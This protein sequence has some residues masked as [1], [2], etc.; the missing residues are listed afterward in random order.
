MR[1]LS[2]SDLVKELDGVVVREGSLSV[3][4]SVVTR[5][6]KVKPGCLY[7]CL[8]SKAPAVQETEQ[9][10]ACV[11]ITSRPKRLPSLRGDITVIQVK[12]TR[13]AYHH[14]LAWYRRLLSTPHLAI[15]GSYGKTTTKEMVKYLLTENHHVK[16][17]K[18]NYNLFRSNAGVLTRMNENTDFGIF[19][20]GVGKKGHLEKCVRCFS[21]FSVLITGIGTDHIERYGSQHL[22]AEEKAKLLKG[23]G[24]DQPIFLNSECDHSKRF[25]RSLPPGQIIWFGTGEQAD[26]RGSHIKYTDE[27]MTFTLTHAEKKYEAF[28]PAFGLHMVRNALG[29]I[30]AAHTFGVDIE[31]LLQR[32][33]TFPPLK[34]HLEI[35]NGLNGSTLI[36]DSWNSNSGSI[37][38]ALAVLQ[39]KSRGKNSVAVLGQINEL[40]PEEIQEHKKIGRLIYNNQPGRLITIGERA[41]VMAREAVKCGMRARHVYMCGTPERALELIQ[42]FADDQTVCLIKTSM[43]D[44]YGHFIRVLKDET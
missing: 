9:L 28:V 41:A 1:K 36:D 13:E 27:G 43:R 4:K 38:A 14:F 37:E 20:F 16:A 6:K 17:T 24:V 31:T 32:L 21:P 35:T 25:A 19:E 33:R 11:M 22:Y 18:G 2:V 15:T 42:K 8:D 10:P 40:G 5:V 26:Y 44:S 3:V 12:K 34:R 7:F 23:A 39:E 30:A 29:A